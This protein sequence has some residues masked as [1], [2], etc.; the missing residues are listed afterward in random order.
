M[1][2]HVEEG[3]ARGE[4]DV[5]GVVDT[6]LGDRDP[7]GGKKPARH[8]EFRRQEVIVAGELRVTDVLAGSL[9]LAQT[10]PHPQG[11]PHLDCGAA[12]L[13][14]ALGEVRVAGREHRARG[15]DR[16]EQHRAH[17]EL[18]DVHV[19]GLFPRR[20]GPQALRSQAVVGGHRAGG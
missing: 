4:R 5:F 7:G 15:V 14:V 13:A 9:P 16:D 17:T 8:G 3:V 1:I 19:A 12:G 2:D 6:V 11:R 18:L 20:D 10:E